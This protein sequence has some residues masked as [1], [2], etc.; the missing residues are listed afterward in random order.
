M[1]KCAKLISNHCFDDIAQ[2]RAP[3]EGQHSLIK[4]LLIFLKAFDR[5]LKVRAIDWEEARYE[6]LSPQNM[7]EKRLELIPIGLDETI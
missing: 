7:I 2:I 5:T 1:A 3:N 4:S 6:F